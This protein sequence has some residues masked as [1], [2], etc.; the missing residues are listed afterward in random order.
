MA[1]LSVRVLWV[2]EKKRKVVT[3]PVCWP[4]AGHQLG[5]SQSSLGMPFQRSPKLFGRLTKY[6]VHII[7]QDDDGIIVAQ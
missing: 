6:G 2:A 7:S 3:L 1:R 4:S 5:V